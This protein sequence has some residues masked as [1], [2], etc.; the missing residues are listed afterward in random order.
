M[1]GQLLRSLLDLLWPPRTRCL[2]CEGPLTDAGTLVCTG[3]LDSMHFEPGEPRCANCNRPTYRSDHICDDCVDG[4]PFGVVF[5]LG[6]HVGPLR[7]A[8]HHFKFGDRPELAPVLGARLA[9][10]IHVPVDCVV[11][12]PLH[13]A[14]LRERGYN[15]S[16]LL[17][18]RIAA[19]V[20]VPLYQTLIRTRDTGHQAKLDRRHR[21][22][23]LHGAFAAAKGQS[24]PWAGQRVL[25]V[26]DVLTTGATAASAAAALYA[27]GARSVD[28][29]VLAVSTTPVRGNL[30]T[31]LNVSRAV[32]DN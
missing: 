22:D 4:A 23:N 19:T 7:E 16:A 2:L 20:H 17:A 9:A 28:L 15:Q 10:A 27:S 29:A 21:L 32:P 25:L 6:P 30:K 13:R 8:V 3:C 5:A 12:V 11:P 1:L 31:R 18:D 26:D 24:V 14:R